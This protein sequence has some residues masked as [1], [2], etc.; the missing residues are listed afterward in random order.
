MMFKNSTRLLFT[1]FDKVWKLL[2]YH[3]LCI[4]ITF[5]FVAIF[6][7]DY[8]TVAKFAYNEA[9]I[10]SVFQS[11]TILGSNIA[12]ALTCIADFFILFFKELF[13]FSIGK[14]IYFC[15]I[16][17][18]FFPV[19]LNIGKYVVCEMMYG[20]M[21]SCR[22]QSFTG[23]YL[24]TLASSLVYSLLKVLYSLPFNALVV[25]S[26]WGLTRVDN[27]I[28][29]YIMPF[30][31]VLIPAILLALKS[32]FNAGWAPAKVVYNHNIFSSFTIGTRAVVR[33]PSEVFASTFVFYLLAIVISIILGAYSLIIILPIMSPLIYIFEMVMF[34]SSQGMRFYVDNDMIISPKK[35][36]EVDKIEDAKYLL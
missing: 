16:V 33:K 6:Y 12:K 20:Y 32:L 31:F 22:K 23:T 7:Q 9:E 18:Y 26:M 10:A 25:L 14:G 2:L 29:D 13:A 8:L 3:I 1:N 24:K 35:L 17:F 4:A 11:G 36:E 34:F 28:F 30:A 21:S 15:F 19:L 5:G 27:H